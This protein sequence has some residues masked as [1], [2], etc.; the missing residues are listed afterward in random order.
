MQEN[1]INTIVSFDSDFVK[2]KTINRIYLD[3]LSYYFFAKF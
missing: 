1:S 3:Y 2:V